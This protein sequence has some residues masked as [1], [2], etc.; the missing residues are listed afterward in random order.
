MG[1]IDK[2]VGYRFHVSLIPNENNRAEHGF[3]AHVMK[4]NRTYF[5]ID[6]DSLKI[7]DPIPSPLLDIYDKQGNLISSMK[8][9]V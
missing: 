4:G 3:H 6:L 5:R 7:L 1:T 8:D 2:A 9:Y